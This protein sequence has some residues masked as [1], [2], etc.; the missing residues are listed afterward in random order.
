MTPAWRMRYR[1]GLLACL[2]VAQVFVLSGCQFR[3]DLLSATAHNDNE[4]VV[5]QVTLG[6]A[7]AKT[8]KLRELYVR[9]T[10]INC[11]S[12]AGGFP[13]DPPIEGGRIPG[14]DAPTQNGRVQIMGRVPAHIYAKYSEPCVFLNGGGYFSG[15][16][17]STVVPIV[18]DPRAGPN[19][20]FKPK[21]LRGSA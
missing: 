17:E 3:P 20:S 1:N 6:A 18:R 15:T 14:F 19:N 7:D 12:T 8:I 4:D 11:N 10:I 16:I 13:A 5:V 9:L 21:P 2:L